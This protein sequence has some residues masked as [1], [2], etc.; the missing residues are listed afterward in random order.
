MPVPKSAKR[1]IRHGSLRLCVALAGFSA[2]AT[3]TTMEENPQTPDPVQQP[4]ALTE[5]E[6]RA[7]LTPEQYRILRQA[8]TERP[9]GEIYAQFKEQG[10]GAYYCAGCGTRLFSAEQK[11]DSHCGWPSFWDPASL[12]S[13]KTRPDHSLGRI[14]T[15]VVCARCE[16]HLGHVFSG[17]GFATPTDQRYCINGGVLVFVPAPVAPAQAGPA[18]AAPGGTDAV[19]DPGPAAPGSEH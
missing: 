18:P 10:A 4:T 19:A 2:V 11:F 15:E 13:V 14:R 1:G 5:A 3:A 6:W 9:F 17:E 12:D 16:G 8:G 7:R